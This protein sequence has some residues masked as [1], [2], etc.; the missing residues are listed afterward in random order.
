VTI[1]GAGFGTT[2]GTVSFAAGGLQKIA[3]ILQWTDGEITAMVPNI[4]AGPAKV[5]VTRGAATSGA[6]PFTVS[7][8]KLIPANFSVA[9]VPAL[10]SGDV[11]ML[12]GSLP[13]LGGWST[14]W[15]DADGP[16]VIPSAGNALLTVSVPAGAKS[17]FKFFVLHADGSVQWEGG[18][19]HLYTIPASGVGAI[20]VNWQP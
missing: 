5:T 11:V 10:A 13:E 20:G 3:K 6:A 12:T 19:N 18:S 16:A 4:S 9:G 1:A 15:N 17:Q 2:A 7:T 14:T 8:G